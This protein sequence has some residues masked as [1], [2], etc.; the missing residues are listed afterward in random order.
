MKSLHGVFHGAF[1]CVAVSARAV[2]CALLTAQLA[3]LNAPTPTPKAPPSFS[4]G[5]SLKPAESFETSRVGLNGTPVFP[6]Y[7]ALS[8]PLTSLQ[9]RARTTDDG[10]SEVV[11]PLWTPPGRKGIQPQL[12]LVYNSRAGPGLAGLGASLSGLSH[13]ARCWKTLAQDGSLTNS[14]VPDEFCL[15][16]VRLRRLPTNEREFRLESDASVRVT[17]S[18]GTPATPA[19]FEVQSQDGLIRTYGSR[20]AVSASLVAIETPAITTGNS[21]LSVVTPGPRQTVAWKQDGLRD[22]W[23]NSLEIDYARSSQGLGRVEVLPSEIRYTRNASLTPSRR[24]RFSYRKATQ[25]RASTSALVTVDSTHVLDAVTV[26]AEVR[27]TSDTGAVG[28]TPLREYR[29]TYAPTPPGKRVEDRLTS[30]VEC[31]GPASNTNAMQCGEPLAFDWADAGDEVPSF[32]TTTVG[33]VVP[34]LHSLTNVA[35]EVTD[36]AVGDFDGDGFDDYLLRRPVIRNGIPVFTTQPGA[37]VFSAEWVLARGSASGLLPPRLLSGLPGSQSSSPE[38]SP[39]VIDFNRDGRDE[40]VLVAAS[41]PVVA[42][43]MQDTE[44]GFT[45]ASLKTYDAYG[46]SSAQGDFTAMAVG[47]TYSMPYAAGFPIRGFAFLAGD[48]TGDLRPDIIRDTGTTC[49]ATGS[50]TARCPAVMSGMVVRAASPSATAFAAPVPL[51]GSSTGGPSVP[52]VLTAGAEAFILDI[53]GNGGPEVLSREWGAPASVDGFSTTLRALSARHPVPFETHLHAEVMQYSATAAAALQATCRGTGTATNGFVRYFADIDGDGQAD[54]LALPSVERDNCGVARSF[55]GVSFTS[56]NVGGQ[57]LPAVAEAVSDVDSLIGPSVL[58]NSNGPVEVGNALLR[59]VDWQGPVRNVDNGLR[60]ADFNRDGRAD[61]VLLGDYKRGLS[62]TPLLRSAPVV[63]F[64]TASGQFSAPRTVGTVQFPTNG[65]YVYASSTASFLLAGR[66]PRDRRLGDFNGDGLVDMARLQQALV[67]NAGV[68][69]LTVDVQAASPADAVVAIRGKSPES[70]VPQ[71]RFEYAFAGPAN[72]GFY[73]AAQTCPAEARCLRKVGWLVQRQHTEAN[74]F[75]SPRP[76]VLTVEY[77]YGEARAD[78]NGRGWLGFGTRRV[79]TP[80]LGTESTRQVSWVKFPLEATR[81]AYQRVETTRA[82]APVQT[83]LSVSTHT[84]TPTLEATPE[85]GYRVA[86]SVATQETKEGGR[87][88]AQTQTDMAFDAFGNAVSV[89]VVS[90]DSVRTET[91]K[92]SRL[93]FNDVDVARWLVNRYPTLEVASTAGGATATRT[94]AF[95]YLPGHV[96]VASVT[97]EP[98]APLETATTSGLTSTE[99]FGYDAY[100]NLADVTVKGDVRP[101]AVTAAPRVT[102]FH[103]DARDALF[104]VGVTNAEGLTTQTF[105]EA[106]TGAVVAVDDENGQRTEV[107]YDAAVRPVVVRWASGEVTSVRYTSASP[108]SRLRS[109]ILDSDAS[110]LSYEDRDPLGRLT[111]RGL[112]SY[113]GGTVPQDFVYDIHSRLKAVSLPRN[114]SWQTPVFVERDYDALGRILSEKRPTETVSS[115]KLERRW[116]YA[117]RLVDGYSERNVRTRSEVDFAGRE[118]ESWTWVDGRPVITTKRYGPFGL[119]A[120]IGH[121]PLNLQMR[122]APPQT[123]LLTSF[124][125]DAL[126]RLSLVVDEDAGPQRRLYSAFG[127]VKQTSDANGGITVFQRDRLGRPTLVET[128]PVSAYPAPP[129]AVSNHA[130]R[131][132]FT[133]DTA[134]NGKGK[135]ASAASVDGVTTTLGYD[136]QSRLASEVVD[137]ATEGTFAFGTLYDAKSR[138]SATLLPA[139]APGAPVVRLERSWRNTDV[140][141]VVDATDANS[142]ELLWKLVSRNGAGQKTEE[143]FGPNASGAVVTRVYDASLQLRLQQSRHAKTDAIFQTLSFTY[144]PDG[145]LTRKTDMSLGLEETYAHDALSRLTQWTVRQNCKTTEWKYVYDDWGNLRE[146]HL[147]GVLHSEN[148]YTKPGVLGP[149][150]GLKELQEGTRVDAYLYLPAGQLASGGANTFSWRPFGL[151]A[152]ISNSNGHSSTYKY[153]AFGRRVLEVASVGGASRRIVTLGPYEKRTDTSGGAL[154]AYSI[155]ADDVVGQLRH[156]TNS[157]G[158][159]LSRQV[160]YFHS[161]NL[162]SPDVISSHG[163]PIERVKYEPYGERRHHW[164]LAHP[165]PASHQA[166]ASYGFTGHQPDDAFGL[167]NMR[168][169]IYSPKTTRFHSP[170]PFLGSDSEALNRFS[171]VRNSPVMLKDPSGYLSVPAFVSNAL[172]G[173]AGFEA[174]ISN[175]GFDA[176]VPSTHVYEAV[177]RGKRTTDASDNTIYAPGLELPASLERPS[178]SG[179]ARGFVATKNLLGAQKLQGGARGTGCY[180]NH[181]CREV[182]LWAQRMNSLAHYKLERDNLVGVDEALFEFSQWVGGHQL[183]M[184]YLG[185][186][187]LTETLSWRERLSLFFSGGE[188]MVMVA[189]GIVSVGSLTRGTESAAVMGAK[190]ARFAVTENGIAIPTNSAELRANLSRLSEVSTSPATSRKFVGVDSQGPVRVRVERAH[191]DDPNFTGTSDPLHTVDH[192]HID[193]RANGQTGPWGSAEKGPYDW[194]F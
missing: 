163:A 31:Y 54:S 35:M 5:E 83:G 172:G 122:P 154:H 38:F 24:I 57:F 70:N 11:V 26:E 39:R 7:A 112:P 192:L 1:H 119:L 166:N 16:G 177:V 19:A 146:R 132:V 93:G 164:A 115:P 18:G 22:V 103:M 36:A 71:T 181:N 92:T 84:T 62:I 183:G 145:L 100:G 168:G 138:V 127:E 182:G 25:P 139:A 66:G 30:I 158:T 69:Q 53:D 126:G 34:N 174:A 17:S 29:L 189:T 75:S 134:L 161:D 148:R 6:G 107:A 65:Y 188:Q 147:D 81:Y 55:Q 159:R 118:V 95:S 48:V 194:P 136:A 98:Q 193:R 109:T 37:V 42:S 121:P 79:V 169:R 82:T 191:P 28:L 156:V 89:Q 61:I 162:G 131:N 176:E 135:L 110:G 160:Q 67:G 49:T 88:V 108:K 33:D 105:F 21:D 153:D 77:A 74:G 13:I 101:G 152:S 151:P 140:E 150:H 144:G 94:T 104:L 47:E 190:K 141:T 46:F 114:T 10:A 3:C 2:L 175:G 102:R 155:V 91:R 14:N 64:G 51:I 178:T 129:G 8:G 85:G 149:A 142:P 56:R 43:T 63:R 58:D 9:Y 113:G 15:D 27:L 157:A 68:Y 12:S 40:V 120:S 96:E 76:D 187:Y 186:D 128:A 123:S 23:G 180:A 165:M 41:T 78:M 80:S 50:T 90:T 170:D 106:A 184:A 167:V 86:A 185:E 60:L 137:I 73:T 173:P 117:A 32:S 87:L 143:Q 44:A 111:R 20:E 125:Y 97:V 133:W 124:T 171:Y 59:P 116:E 72:P 99:A 4:P 45:T 52:A 130:Q 179:N